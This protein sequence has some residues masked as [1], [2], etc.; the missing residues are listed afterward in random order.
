M[1][2]YFQ[3]QDGEE[4]LTLKNVHTMD[5]SVEH[6][7]RV[8]ES[9]NPIDI[10]IGIR[11]IYSDA[12]TPQDV[13]EIIEFLEIPEFGTIAIFVLVAAILTL[14]A[15]RVKPPRIFEKI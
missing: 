12:E 6:Q 9:D 11:G 7:T 15:M 13:D 4:I 10:E 8:L 5:G 3:L 1:V 2:E 14:I